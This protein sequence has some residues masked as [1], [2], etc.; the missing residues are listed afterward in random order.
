MKDTWCWNKVKWQQSFKFP[1]HPLTFMVM[2]FHKVSA[3]YTYWLVIADQWLLIRT[4]MSFRINQEIQCSTISATPTSNSVW[5]YWRYMSLDVIVWFYF[6]FDIHVWTGCAWYW[7]MILTPI[8]W[9]NRAIYTIPIPHTKH[10]TQIIF[11]C[12]GIVCELW[13]VWFCM[14]VNFNFFFELFLW[15]Y[16]L[17]YS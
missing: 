8:I 7:R 9:M 4:Q 1:S 17:F 12:D 16:R 11:L 14:R 3:A 13:I 5:V 2:K 10:K 15:F 6:I